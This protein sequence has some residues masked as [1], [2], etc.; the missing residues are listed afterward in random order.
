MVFVLADIKRT[1]YLDYSYPLFW[2]LIGWSIALALSL[3]VPVVAIINVVNNSATKP[4]TKASHVTMG[5]FTF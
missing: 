1:T 5:N 2:E 4:L 3:C